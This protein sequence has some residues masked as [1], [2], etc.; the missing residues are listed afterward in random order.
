VGSKLSHGRQ[1]ERKGV[2]VDRIKHSNDKHMNYASNVVTY[3]L[4]NFEKVI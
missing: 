3:F 4:F 1:P 2:P